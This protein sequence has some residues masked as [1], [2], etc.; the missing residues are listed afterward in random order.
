MVRLFLLHLLPLALVAALAQPAD[1]TQQRLAPGEPLTRVLVAA[2]VEAALRERG[3]GERFEVGVET[4]PLPL[5]NRAGSPADLVLDGLRHEPRGGRFTASLRVRLESG[6]A[7]TIEL[8]GQARELVEVSVPARRIERGGVIEAADLEVRW[9]RAA[10]FGTTTPGI[11]RS[12]SAGRRVASSPSGAPCAPP[13]S[14]SRGSSSG[15]K[16]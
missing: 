8:A 2:L 6:E 9:W 12:W 10:W 14:P 11:L 7:S 1:A 5:A 13:T 3:A 15:A 4:P 16:R